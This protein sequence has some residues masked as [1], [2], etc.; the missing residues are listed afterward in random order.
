[1]EA[2]AEPTP[3]RFYVVRQSALGGNASACWTHWSNE[4]FGA[5]LKHPMRTRTRSRA[6]LVF[7]ELE[8]RFEVSAPSIPLLKSFAFAGM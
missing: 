4:T 6:Q 2:R 3:L 1:M 7:G 5:L 8:S